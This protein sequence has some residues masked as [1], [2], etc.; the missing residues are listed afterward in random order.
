[1]G[2]RVYLRA[3]EESDLEFIQN[4]RSNEKLYEYTCGNKYFISSERTR[5]WIDNKIKDNYNQIYL[6][7]C[8]SLSHK[9]VGYVCATGLDYVNRKA[10]FAGIVIGKDYQG[11][12]YGGEATK[13][14]VDHLIKEL[15]FNMVF[16]YWRVDHNSSIKMA[17]KVGFKNSGLMR[18]FVFKKNKFHDAYL[19][20]II[21]KEYIEN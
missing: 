15:N 11:K 6:L 3:F 9:P 13:L 2:N 19:F 18:D 20:S 14:M 8:E 7:V 5:S 16:G 21:R 10:K 12:G 4:I 1:M 17:E